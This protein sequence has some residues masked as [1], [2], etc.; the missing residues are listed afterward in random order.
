MSIKYLS[1]YPV[2]SHIL[3]GTFKDQQWIYIHLFVLAYP[4]IHSSPF[5]DHEVIANYS[6]LYKIKGKN[7]TLKPYLIM[8]HLDVVPTDQL[9]DV[10]PFASEIRDGF[11]YARGSLDAK[12]I[13]FVSLRQ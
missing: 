6:L 4:T 7:E 9:W 11:I 10:P 12:Q 1:L 5:V 2:K 13:V 3:S 8:G